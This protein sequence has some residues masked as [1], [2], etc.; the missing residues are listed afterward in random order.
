[1]QTTHERSVKTEKKKILTEEQSKRDKLLIEKAEE[2]K[3]A[4]IRGLEPEVQKMIAV[5][6]LS[7]GSP[8]DSL[9]T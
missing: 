8:I 1:M 2:I 6:P 3:Q 9:E 5:L 7:A 4:T